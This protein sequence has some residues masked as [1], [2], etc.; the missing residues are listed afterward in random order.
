VVVDMRLETVNALVAEAC[1][2]GSYPEQW[3]IVG[4]KERAADVLALD[5]PLD[6][7]MQEDSLEP[8]LIEQRLVDLANA[9]MDAKV[10]SSDASIWRQ[11]EKQVLLDRLDYYWKEH[12]ATLDALRQVVFLRAYAQKQPINEYKQE[13]FGLFERMLETIREDV[14]RILMTSELR[15]AAPEEPQETLPELPSFLTG[16]IDP[17]TG[18]DDSNDGDGSAG[19]EAFFG[20][21]AGSPRAAVGPGGAATEDPYR[22]MKVSRNAPC[23]CGSGNKYK[24]CHGALA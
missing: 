13:A 11:V 15:I 3:N 7:W 8:E 1:P 16:H 14:T 19:Q 24:H 10:A 12:L 5:A 18:L 22:D 2:P 17:F 21:L 4:L 20:S 9:Q 23:P 6:D